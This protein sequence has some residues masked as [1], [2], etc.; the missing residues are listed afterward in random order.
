[1]PDSPEITALAQRLPWLKQPFKNV[2]DISEPSSSLVKRALR[3]IKVGWNEELWHGQLWPVSAEI[4]EAHT[5]VLNAVL[6]ARQAAA[7][8]AQ[9][10]QQQAIEAVR[11]H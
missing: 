11:G 8:K 7:E 3:L 2:N 10:Q 6:Q 9:Y 4:V 1:M 5:K